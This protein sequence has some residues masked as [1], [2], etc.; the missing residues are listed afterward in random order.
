[1]DSYGQQVDL[2]LNISKPIGWTSFDVVRFIQK[3]YRIKKV[4]HAGT[5]DPFADGVLLV[6][7][8]RATKQIP[9]LMEAEKEYL[10]TL[11]FGI[12][13]DTLDLSGRPIVEKTGENVSQEAL[14]KVLPRFVGKIT[15][16]PPVYSALKINGKRAYDLA[17][18]GQTVSLEP[19]LVEIHKIELLTFQPSLATIRVVCSKGTYIRSLARDIAAE[20]KSVAFLKKLTR[21]R[22]GEYKLQ[23]ALKI[24]EVFPGKNREY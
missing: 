22:V 11:Q 24:T 7:C 8:G 1:M 21:L 12:E 15:Q 13:T 4:G 3:N 17:R 9:R 10:A 20:L 6:C 23:D 14:R 19:R 5:L 16:K 18:D 2:V